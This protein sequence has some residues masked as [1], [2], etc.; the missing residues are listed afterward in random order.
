MDEVRCPY[1]LTPLDEG[2]GECECDEAS[3]RRLEAE[4][5]KFDREIEELHQIV[6]ILPGALTTQALADV[7]AELLRA[8]QHHAVSRLLKLLDEERRTAVM[9]LIP[10]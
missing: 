9:D 6:S 5:D 8:D 2:E 7:A 1:C 3:I 10:D 4:M